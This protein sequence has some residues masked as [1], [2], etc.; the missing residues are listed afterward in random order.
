MLVE[1]L[2]S[3]LPKV[4]S[5][6][7]F[8]EVRPLPNPLPPWYKA[9]FYYNYHHAEGHSMDNCFTLR[10]A[11]Q[12]LI[13]QKVI[14][15]NTQEAVSTSPPPLAST[16]ASALAPPHPSIMHH[17]LPEHS[18]SGGAGTSIVH[19]LFPSRPTTSVVD[20]STLI[21]LA[22]DPFLVTLYNSALAGSE[23]AIHIIRL[24]AE[25]G[26]SAD[27]P[28]MQ[29]PVEPPICLLAMPQPE[30]LQPSS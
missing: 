24:N 11:I 4:M 12:D 20:P 8:P 18:S 3:V 25:P 22:S 1:P 16:L 30:P 5:L 6:L 29:Q 2:S 13:D 10:G 21:H 28:T 14:A 17:P 26:P 27:R 9:G 23:S 19:A 7:R 15:I